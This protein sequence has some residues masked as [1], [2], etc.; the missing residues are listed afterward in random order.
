MDW[1][2]KC[3]VD[4]YK[5]VESDYKL[6]APSLVLL[7]PILNELRFPRIHVLCISPISDWPNHD[8]SMLLSRRTIKSDVQQPL[9]S[10]LPDVYFLSADHVFS[11][12][13][14]STKSPTN[15]T[16]I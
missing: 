8:E 4:Y 9:P 10:H 13:Q 14:S 3:V 6:Q 12:V 15:Q 7:F 16:K 5:T 2:E 11:R 1:I